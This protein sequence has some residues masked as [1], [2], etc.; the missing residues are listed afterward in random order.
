MEKKFPDFCLA[1]FSKINIPIRPKTKKAPF[2]R[3]LLIAGSD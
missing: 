3:S 2:S 1:I